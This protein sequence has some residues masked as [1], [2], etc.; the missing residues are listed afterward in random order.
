MDK[1]VE[2]RLDRLQMEN[3]ELKAQLN[4]LQIDNEK[5]KKEIKM[6]IVANNNNYFYDRFKIPY[7]NK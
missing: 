7:N 5:L 2:T 6:L 3:K 1:T 4:I